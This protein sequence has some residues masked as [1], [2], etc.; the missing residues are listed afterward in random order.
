LAFFRKLTHEEKTL[1][2]KT[3][4]ILRTLVVVAIVLASFLQ[5]SSSDFSPVNSG[6]HYFS[7]DTSRFPLYDR[8]GD[9][10]S[11]PNRNTFD[12]K[13]TGFIKRNIEYDPKTKQYYIVEKIGEK[14]YRTPTSFTM[15]EFVRLQGKKDE[16]DYFK[17]RA[18]LLSNMNRRMF[19]P[20]FRVSNDW[21]NRIMGTGPDGKVKIDIK[22]SGYVD[23]LAGY[24]GQNIKNPTLPER[25]R[26]NGGFDFNMNSQLQMDASIGEKLKLPIN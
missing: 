17:K 5:A 9:P 4:H 22:P 23:F 19:K 15:E 7:A 1:N 24:Q 20:K 26:R 6:Y 21:F 3:A 2:L 18:S 11:N 10:Y 13:D 25:A 12:L 8:Y 14:Y 16:Q